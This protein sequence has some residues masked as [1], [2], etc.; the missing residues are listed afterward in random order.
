MEISALKI[1]PQMN[2]NEEKKW[3]QRGESGERATCR[4]LSRRSQGIDFRTQEMTKKSRGWL[5][6]TENRRDFLVRELT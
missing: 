5:S 4:T 1:K 2:S 3:T 6:E